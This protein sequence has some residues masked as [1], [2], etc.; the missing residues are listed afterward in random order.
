MLSKVFLCMNQTT[1]IE[2]KGEMSKRKGGDGDQPKGSQLSRLDLSGEK[3]KPDEEIKVGQR[4]A[5]RQI[6]SPYDTMRRDLMAAFPT[7]PIVAPTLLDPKKHSFMDHVTILINMKDEA[8]L[9]RMLDQDKIEPKEVPYVFRA[10]VRNNLRPVIAKMVDVYQVN[11]DAAAQD[12]ILFPTCN[13]ITVKF[14]LTLWADAHGETLEEAAKQMLEKVGKDSVMIDPLR[15]RILR[16]MAGMPDRGLD[17]EEPKK[18]ALPSRED[19]EKELKLDNVPNEQAVPVYI[20]SVGDL[21]YS[22]CAVFTPN[23]KYVLYHTRHYEVKLWV[24]DVDALDMV[25]SIAINHRYPV[26]CIAAAQDNKTVYVASYNQIQICDLDKIKVVRTI[27]VAPVTHDHIQGIQAMALSP[28]DKYLAIGDGRGRVYIIDVGTGL[29]VRDLS[30]PSLHTVALRY[31][32]DGAVLVWNAED[33]R[34][35]MWDTQTGQ[36][37]T[38]SPLLNVSDIAASPV[39]SVLAILSRNGSA[40]RL[41]D[42]ATRKVIRTFRLPPEKVTTVSFSPHGTKLVLTG[43]LCVIVDI[44]TAGVVY[45]ASCGRFPPKSTAVSPVDYRIMA[46]SSSIGRLF[47]VA[48]LRGGKGVK[49]LRESVASGLA[50]SANPQSAW[51]QFLS[52]G[53]YDPR[54]F[55]DIFGY[56]AEF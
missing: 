41:W 27:E 47:Y 54:L 9:V 33:G 28:D 10:V 46:H 3:R 30:A 51:D 21:N 2:G 7:T 11:I 18:I 13:P 32:F 35:A 39:E 23:G 56:I 52:R 26:H 8:G 34:A 40:L 22:G 37:Y 25:K 31:S 12:A 16:E 43:E 45:A 36:R 53:L 4:K 5:P 1:R 20:N 48:D 17:E 14:V 6:E 49:V 42:M 24:F 38:E 19:E 29:S 55:L 15:L 50:N 44:A